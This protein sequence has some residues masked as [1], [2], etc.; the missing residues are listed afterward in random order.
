MAARPRL[1]L[2]P[3]LDGILVVLGRMTENLVDGLAET[4]YRFISAAP[5]FQNL[6]ENE[7]RALAYAVV[8]DLV[9]SPI[10]SPLD[11]PL[12]TVIQDRIR[13]LMP[14]MD[15]YLRMTAKVAEAFPYLELL[16]NYTAA[17]LAALREK[18]I[19]T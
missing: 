2:P 12:D 15:R 8:G 9:A 16:P 7:R 3:L 10:P 5:A 6:T 18:E 11:V 14:E 13:S 17:V 19:Q 1:R 4:A